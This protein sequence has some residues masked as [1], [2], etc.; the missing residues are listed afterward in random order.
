MELMLTASRQM[1][2]RGSRN[3]YYSYPQLGLIAPSGSHLNN[4]TETPPTPRSP[5]FSLVS[6]HLETQTRASVAPL[7]PQI[8]SFFSQPVI[9][10]G[11]DHLSTHDPLFPASVHIESVPPLK[12]KLP[13]CYFTK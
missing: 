3:N 8:C 11:P 13:A 5:S 7:M 6:F 2:N 10:H 12:H 4:T 1:P 9:R